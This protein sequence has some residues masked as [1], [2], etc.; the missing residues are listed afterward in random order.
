ML[1]D[2]EGFNH[3]LARTMLGS[4]GSEGL[5]IDEAYATA[6]AGLRDVGLRK[7][8]WNRA[9][10]HRTLVYLIRIMRNDKYPTRSF[11]AMSHS[12]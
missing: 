8:G 1:L 4:F 6:L 9:G 10:L 7:G 12:S 3:Y 5:G 2:K 11:M